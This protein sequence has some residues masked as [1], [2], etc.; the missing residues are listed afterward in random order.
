VYVFA[1]YCPRIPVVKSWIPEHRRIIQTVDA[2]PSTGSPHI[3][4]LIT[5]KI[6]SA[7]EAR[8]NKMPNT[9]A[10]ASGFDEKAI[11]PSNA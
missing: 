9:E 8:K 4:F 5:I 11:I 2:Q 3:N 6:I 10:I 7:R 1:I